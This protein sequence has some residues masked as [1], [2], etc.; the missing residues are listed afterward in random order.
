MSLAGYVEVDLPKF[1]IFARSLFAFVRFTRLKTLKNSVR[2][3]T[4]APSFPMNHG[5]LMFLITEKSVLAYPGPWKVLRPRLPSKPR[6]GI[7][8][9]LEQ[10]GEPAQLKMPVR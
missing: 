4:F 3:C 9:T 7:G 5:I 8:N 6:F 2:N 10:K 1:E